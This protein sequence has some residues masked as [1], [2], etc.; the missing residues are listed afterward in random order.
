MSRTINSMVSTPPPACGMLP[1]DG[2][3]QRMAGGDKRLQLPRGETILLRVIR[4]VAPLGTD[5]APNAN[6]DAARLAAYGAP[7]VPDSIPDFVG[8]LAG[9]LA[10]LAG[11][12][13][14]FGHIFGHITVMSQALQPTLRSVRRSCQATLMRNPSGSGCA[15]LCNA[16]RPRASGLRYPAGR[17]M[18]GA[19]TGRQRSGEPQAG[20][21]DPGFALVTVEHE[22]EY[23][24]PVFI[25]HKS[26]PRP[27]TGGAPGTDFWVRR[28][29]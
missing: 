24:A 26:A 10:G 27:R 16:A 6:R 5:L 8:P 2:R 22:A 20:P 4:C 3:S 7:V 25:Q 18:R 17:F 29:G 19:A 12:Q 13:V 9:T 15:R 11:G 28:P 1:A 14:F 23:F 21:M